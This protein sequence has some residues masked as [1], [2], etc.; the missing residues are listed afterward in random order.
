M[1]LHALVES[2]FYDRID[3]EEFTLNIILHNNQK[4]PI[5]VVLISPYADGQPV[6]F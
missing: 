3:P 5:D 6:P 1:Q 2:H 4:A